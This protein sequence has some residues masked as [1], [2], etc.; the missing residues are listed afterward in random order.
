MTTLPQDEAGLQTLLAGDPN[1]AEAHAALGALILRRT[2]PEVGAV[3]SEDITAAVLHLRDAINL[4]HRTRDVI[5][6]FTETLGMITAI[7]SRW[8]IDGAFLRAFEEGVLSPLDFRPALMSLLNGISQHKGSIQEA[9]T[10]A[11]RGDEQALTDF[12]S[13]G[14]LRDVFSHPALTTVM[15]S[16]LMGS[17]EME[18]LFTSMRRHFLRYAL[19]SD[20]VALHPSD[21]A[22]CYALADQCFLTEYAYWCEPEETFQCDVL[23]ETFKAN[24]AE[25]P[26]ADPFPAAVLACYKPLSSFSWV[27]KL[28]QL[29]PVADLGGF[30]EI[31]QR[32]IREPATERDLAASLS[33]VAEITDE[34]SLG[35][36]QQYE[37]NPYPRWVM[38]VISPGE[39]F[40]EAARTKYPSADFTLFGQI[41]RP[42]ILIAG[43]GTG[44]QIMHMVSGYDAWNLTGIDMSR[45]SL[46]YAQ[47]QIQ[48][49]DVPDVDLM[50]CDI[51]NVGQLGKQ[52]DIIEC[53][54][55]LHHMAEPLKGWRALT[56]VLQPGGIMTI[57]LYS[58]AARRT[59]IDAQAYAAAQGYE[60]NADGIRR[61]RHEIL[62]AVRKPSSTREGQN[63]AKIGNSL[64]AL[65][66]F[67]SN[68]MCRDLVFH[69]QERNFSLTEI[70]AAVTA[71]GLNF[72]G[73]RFKSG[74]VAK[75]YFSRFPNDPNGTD[76]SNWIVFEQ[77]NPGTFIGMYNFDV[78]KPL[79]S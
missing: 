77:E 52:F 58:A 34:T 56:E 70:K 16:T 64:K 42:E 41:A 18:L 37:E 48:K 47:R 68:S 49:F 74:T 44:Q 67:Y 57:G 71:L 19:D 15:K 31:V 1:N 53:V 17:L 73:F 46:A 33:E 22:F 43:C 27:Y 2:T 55:V 23:A 54:G 30:G 6:R 75:S 78:Q 21:R 60:P 61:F 26:Y 24:L 9:V 72:L 40:H 76:L 7:P 62:K 69:V 29:Y 8:K 50:V 14:G 51:L 12:I 25:D 4:G 36:K 45:A 20:V 66:D 39:P 28:I 10:L 32:H 63:A 59:V 3:P 38:P 11:W 35:V 5:E 13:I 79:S 65:H